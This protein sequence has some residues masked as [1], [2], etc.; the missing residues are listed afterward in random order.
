MSWIPGI[1]RPLLEIL[2]LWG[3]IYWTLVLIQGTRAVQV[4]RGL[5]VVLLFFFLTQQ[6][7]L[8]ALS[9]ALAKLLAIGVI[10]FLIIFQPE[11]R[12]GLAQLGRGRFI[13]MI[14][15][16]EVIG[17]IVEAAG[18]LSRRR[19]GML[20]AIER[21]VGLKLYVDGGVTVDGR[22]SNELLQ[23]IF[24]P[25]APLHD[26]GVV[27]Q[28]DHIASCGSLFP[29][30]QNTQVSKTLG[31]RH[32]AALGLSEETDAICVVVSEETGQISVAAEGRLELGLS[33]TQLHERLRQL[34]EIPHQRVPVLWDRWIRWT[35]RKGTP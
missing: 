14:L 8:H 11:L 33:P 34:F 7:G 10:A 19:V 23:T 32:R 28:N 3:V 26:G 1:W 4:L 24:T 13:G 12:R 22:V 21:Q 2:V 15:R 30:T 29:L 5:V 20:I 35:S 17:E 16:E 18:G 9:W 6:L 27:I 25:H 31:T